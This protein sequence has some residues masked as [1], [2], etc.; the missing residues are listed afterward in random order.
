MLKKLVRNFKKKLYSLFP[1]C[2][3]PSVGSKQMGGICVGMGGI[4]GMWGMGWECGESEWEF[5]E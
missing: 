4:R 1:F 2:I 5:G 3:Y